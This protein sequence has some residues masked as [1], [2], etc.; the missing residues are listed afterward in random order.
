M[1][2]TFVN[3]IRVSERIPE[4]RKEVLIYTAYGEIS[5]GWNENGTW[6]DISDG[7]AGAD[8]TWWAEKPDGPEENDE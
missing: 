6:H 5:L 8:V 7:H 1:K 2:E 3:W 4:K